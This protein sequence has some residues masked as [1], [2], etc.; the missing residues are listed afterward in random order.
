M[1]HDVQLGKLDYGILHSWYRGALDNSGHYGDGEVLFP[2]DAIVWRKLNKGEKTGDPVP[3]SERNIEM[4]LLWAEEN[5][6]HTAINVDEYRL[7]KKLL[8]VLGREIDDYSH[9]SLK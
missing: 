7:I 1:F 8:G 9:F 5:I 2:D 6:A 4:I 3:L